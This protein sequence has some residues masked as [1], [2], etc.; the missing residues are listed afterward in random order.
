MPRSVRFQPDPLDSALIDFQPDRNPFQPTSVALILNESYTG[1]ALVTKK[2]VGLK[3]NQWIRV[4]V[5]R[6][7]V[8][9]ARIVW[10]K[11]IDETLAKIGVEFME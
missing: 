5:G 7:A 8:M 2:V 6:L 10:I 3:E 4:Q 1:C 11:D 9:D